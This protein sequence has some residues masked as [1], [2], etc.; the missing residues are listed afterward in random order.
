M[1]SLGGS[2]CCRMPRGQSPRA[3]WVSLCYWDNL[4]PLHGTECGLD[5]FSGRKG[6]DPLG[7]TLLCLVLIILLPGTLVALKYAN[8]SSCSKSSYLHTVQFY[9]NS[10]VDWIMTPI[11]AGRLQSQNS[12]YWGRR[13]GLSNELGVIPGDRRTLFSG[14]PVLF[15]SPGV[16][17]YRQT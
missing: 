8:Y 15:F 11:C 12:L 5:S 14:H 1:L 16:F 9:D 13:P 7:T 2:L 3:Q 17:L 4:R 6:S 10:Q